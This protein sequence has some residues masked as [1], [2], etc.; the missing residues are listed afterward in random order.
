MPLKLLVMLLAILQIKYLGS[1]L[2]KGINQASYCVSLLCHFD[3]KFQAW[4]SKLLSAAGRLIPIH[5]VLCS[6]PAHIIASSQLPKS[7]LDD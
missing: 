6:I 4:S 2:Y 3:A 1:Y 7:I 5:H